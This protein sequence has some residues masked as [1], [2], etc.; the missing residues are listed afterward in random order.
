MLELELDFDLERLLLL[1]DKC[2]PLAAPPSCSC[3]EAKPYLVSV[4]FA[5]I[6]M[7]V[8]ELHKG[9]VP[10]PMILLVLLLGWTTNVSHTPIGFSEYF[11]GAG[12]QSD[13][14]STVA[15]GHAHDLAN[16]VEF[17]LWLL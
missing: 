9:N 6:A 5:A 7:V 3:V 10:W 13:A 8:Q 4:G 15:R 1:V 12:A 17:R 14:L 11:A 16:G 2:L